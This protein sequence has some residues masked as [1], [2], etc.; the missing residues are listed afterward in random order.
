MIYP[1]TVNEAI[2]IATS[3]DERGF[4]LVPE[5]GS[6]LAALVQKLG[7]SQN[8]GEVAATYNPD[9]NYISALS[10]NFGSQDKGQATTFAVMLDNLSADIGG[11][12]QSHL[13]YA[14][15][16]VTPVI[17]AF[18]DEL[19][20]DVKAL[21]QDPAGEYKI[22]VDRIPAP[23]Q[24]ASLGDHLNSYADAKIGNM[25]SLPGE[26]RAEQELVETITQAVP[27]LET[28]L[29]EW[30]GTLQEGFLAKVWSDVFTVRGAQGAQAYDYKPNAIDANLAIYLLA[31][32]VVDNPA[33]GSGVSLAKWNLM[34]NAL[35][36]RSGQ[37]LAAALTI[38]T[39]Q[40]KLGTLITGYF[41]KTITV[42]Q[43]VYTKWIAGGGSDQLLIAAVSQANVPTSYSDINER[44]QELGRAW[45]RYTMLRRSIIESKKFVRMQE[46]VAY[47]LPLVVRDFSNQI[48]D[49]FGLTGDAGF[50]T[51]PVHQEFHRLLKIAVPKLTSK[52]F[53]NVWMLGL[54]LVCDTVFHF[55]DSKAILLGRQ[56]AIEM[57]PGITSDESEFLSRISYVIDYVYDQLHIVNL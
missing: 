54:T 28:E 3:L 27:G 25:E 46:L 51:L 19:S 48:Y 2:Q 13:S 52:D 4:K 40:E 1:D 10:D 45:E 9:P 5:T 34:A 21:D 37:Q 23:L 6:P 8:E 24:A 50:E 33:E 43:N 56:K 47:R 38:K 14:K 30:V 39:N 31:G 22:V 15:N 29:K 16:V 49:A 55:T 36:I 11:A 57:N 42:N 26:D 44:A 17:K 53:D 20:K 7:V 41:D 35:H 18:V 12:V 32:R